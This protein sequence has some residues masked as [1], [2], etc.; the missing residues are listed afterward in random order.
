L[1]A[2]LDR[3]RALLIALGERPRLARTRAALDRFNR[4]SGGLLAAG[5]SYNAV[6]ALV[7][8][9]VLSAGLAGFILDDPLSQARF[10]DAVVSVLPPL[11]GVIDE[12]VSGLAEASPSLSIIGLALAGWGTSRLFAS[13]DT[14]IEQVFAGS[15]SRHFV[16]RTIRRLGSVAV[17]AIIVVAALIVIPVLS[18]VGDGIRATGPL[19]GALLTVALVAVTVVV[20]GLALAAI[21]RVMPPHRPSWTSIRLPAAAIALG[22]LVLTRAFVVLAPRL[23]GT[24]LVYGAL[25][26]IFVGLVWLDLVFRLI[27]VGAAWVCERSIAEV[28]GSEESPLV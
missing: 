28:T 15:P 17:M 6:F 22:L 20:A 3:A 21:Y 25:G 10:V 27:L 5:L 14:A 2:R 24:N 19:E 11:R 18:V 8:I 4:A 12:I 1:P 9:A 16:S 13:L 26:A 7:P 23:L